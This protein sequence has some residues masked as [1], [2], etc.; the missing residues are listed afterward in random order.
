MR[1]NDPPLKPWVILTCEGHVLCAHCTC[2]AGIA[3]SCTHVGALLFAIEAT[4][5]LRGTKTVTDVPSYWAVPS[6]IRKVQ[7]EVAHK[8]DFTTAKAKR[9]ALDRAIN[10]GTPMPGPRSRPRSVYTHQSTLSDLGPLLKDL[11]EERAACMA[12]TEEYYKFYADPVKPAKMPTPLQVRLRDPEFRNASLNEILQ[13]CETVTNVAAV[14][15]ED[16]KTIRTRTMKQHK[17][18]AW[19]G[20]RAGRVTASTMHAV[21]VSNID[22]PAV[23]TVK[24]VCYPKAH[25]ATADTQW[26]LTHEDT[27][28]TEYLQQQAPHHDNLTIEQSGFC[29]NPAF[30]QVGAS[31]DGLVSCDCCGQ[32]CLEVKC[33]A[34]HKHSTVQEACDTDKDFCLHRVGG[35][36]QL[37]QGHRYYTQVQTQMFVTGATYCDF[38]VWTL[39]DVAVLRI[40]P[41]V[42]FWESCL[43]KAQEFFHK[44]CL[45]ELICGYYT[46]DTSTPEATRVL[47][48][49]TEPA[50]A[51]APKRPRM[52]KKTTKKNK[53]NVWC[54]CGGPEIDT[55]VLC[56][57]SSCTIQWFHLTCVGL[58]AD[59]A[60][61]N[62]WFCDACL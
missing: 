53:E 21:L 44:V 7:G 11:H 46:R 18:P 24:N 59:S 10:D 30:P 57:N 5:R 49:N 39:K 60:K 22:K 52:S 6:A 4:V 20:V 42:S 56:D 43:R 19:F 54:V 34:K 13:H 61:E 27:A 35:I 38:V 37:K 50:P 17:A 31:P 28:R 8:M 48:V 58:D 16:A 2:M 3:E 36:V 14:S 47:A 9:I 29:I 23:S 12:A 45:P 1:Q 55:M 41:D 33:P 25:F 40:L 51:Q 15:H 62:S 26:G 32:G